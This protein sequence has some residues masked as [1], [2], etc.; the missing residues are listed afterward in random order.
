MNGDWNCNPLHAGDRVIYCG[1][2]AR[3]F[4][5][6]VV[7]AVDGEKIAIRLFTQFDKIIVVQSKT[8]V[9]EAQNE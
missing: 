5:P 6:A 2:R 4:V 8:V 1:N 3:G 9:L 7:V